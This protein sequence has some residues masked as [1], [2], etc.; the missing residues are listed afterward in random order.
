MKKSFLVLSLLGLA[1]CL[2]QAEPGHKFP[3]IKP[4]EL[5]KI[6]A[7]LPDAKVKPAQPRRLLVFYRTEGFVHGSIPYGN[8]AFKEIGDKTGAYT[9]DLS[10]DMAVFTPEGLKPYDAV[11]FNSTTNLQFADPAARQALLDFVR[12]GK[13]VIGIHAATDNFRTWPEGQQLMGGLFKSH[14]WVSHDIEAV[15]VDDP[16]HPLSE[17]F[18][19]VGFWI[20]DEIY[21]IMG[22]YDRAQVRVLLSLDM[23]KPQNQRDPK[24]IVRTDNDF[25]I[26]WVKSI[27]GGGRV[28]YCSL[29]H[30]P[31]IFWTK[32]VLQHYL[33]GIQFALGDLKADALPSAK[34]NPA[35]VAALAPDAPNPLNPPPPHVPKPA[36][37]PA[38]A[39]PKTAAILPGYPGLVLRA[40]TLAVLGAT[41]AAPASADP[42][43]DGVK[44]LSV[45]DYGLDRTGVQAFL[46]YVRAQ[47]AANHPK[48]EAALVPLLSNSAV[49]VGGK[50][51][52][53]RL[54][55]ITGSDSSVSAIA[56][57]ISDP[58]LSQLAV[59]AL[60]EIGTPAAKQA[61]AGSLATVPA[62]LR[63][64]VIGALGRDHVTE[65]APALAKLAAG[66]DT[67]SALAAIDAL[68]AL[69]TPDAL[70]DLRQVNG[71]A[72]N[73]TTL[74]WAL[75]R[76]A[77]RVSADDAKPV[78]TAL[79]K[80]GANSAVR[81]AAATGYVRVDPAGAWAAISGLL[82]DPDRH[83]RLDTARL[84]AHL[85][86]A[87]VGDLLKAFPS[88][89]PGV[90]TVIVNNFA[91]SRASDC[92][93]VL[94]AALA[95][96]NPDVH[97]AA[98]S[99]YGT[100]NLATSAAVLIPFLAKSKPEADAASAS[101]AQLSDPA[102]SQLLPAQLA[103]SSGATR[104]GLLA[105][106]GAR[107]EYTLKP[108]VYAATADPDATV[109]DAAFAAVA[110]LVKGDDLPAV[111]KLLPLTKDGAQRK[112]VNTA[113]A[114][115][116]ALNPDK[117]AAVD[118]LTPALTGATPDNR[119]A[120]IAA[121]AS[122]DS[123]KAA[124]ALHTLLQAPAVEDR[125]EVIRALSTVRNSNSDALLFEVA[126]QGKETS[127]RI[128][129][130]RGYLDSIQAQKI[131]PSTLLDDYKK[132]WPLAQRQEEKDAI[133]AAIKNT[134]G[135]AAKKLLTELTPEADST[136]TPAT[137]TN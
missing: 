44:A 129:A 57:L 93:P 7:A 21:Q 13:G 96:A 125:K 127:E 136:T 62:K 27:D 92:E 47:G 105:V 131:A 130:L 73:Q 134:R 111:L 91:A 103:Q 70:S 48:V 46:D 39:P 33:D 36:T 95:S 23:S 100:A 99:G 35:P 118:L 15:K 108:Q 78:Y 26:S 43:G 74:D 137:S 61:L 22:P 75:L 1:T 28:F 25:P 86:S 80:S 59:N 64:A 90:Q 123:D 98:L 11:L 113:L 32:P 3:P 88:L 76:A 49:P 120:L 53:L 10:D 67:V 85:P 20:N 12:S 69:G 4:D 128:L 65:A 121:L 5:A 52:A 31:S 41:T 18:G 114:H 2:G 38:P 83:V 84:T 29:G 122:I 37:P 124:A 40:E 6:A 135:A 45:Y 55:G 79:I 110:A 63:P 30:N 115:A 8:E 87:G 107:Q 133:L 94:Q 77:G 50:D 109:A 17:A 71:G 24:K 9:A 14:P 116:A 72:E 104:A 82:A 81:V 16:G 101:L 106:I 19:G 97:L 102:I 126:S 132:A 58:A 112:S 60:F 117:G 89:D 56:P 68:A 34:E 51:Y 119:Q 54:L 66:D 42:L